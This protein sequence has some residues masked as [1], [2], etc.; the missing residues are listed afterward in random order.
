MV[1][2]QVRYSGM[3]LT[4]LLL[5]IAFTLSGC[6]TDPAPVR[7]PK[8]AEPAVYGPADWMG[9][10]GSDEG[11]YAALPGWDLAV[12]DPALGA[13]QLSCEAFVTRDPALPLSDAAPW[14]GTPRD[15]E[16]VCAALRAAADGPAGRAVLEALMTPLE[17]LDPSGESRFTGY[18]EPTYPARL[19][20]V[21]P[22][23][24]P[25]PALPSDHLVEGG[26]VLQRLPN[27]RTRP[28]PDR[29]TI[30][31]AGVRPLAYARPADVFFLQIQ[32]SGRLILPDGRTLRAAYAGHNGHAFQSTANWLIRRGWLPRSQASMTGIKTWMAR[33]SD[34]RMREA[35][36]ANPRFIFFRLEEEGDPALGPKGSMGVPLTPLG[37]VAVDLSYHA[38]G[39][40]LFVQTAAP[41]LGG[42]WS[43]LLVAQDTGNAIRGPVRGDIYFGTGPDAGS[44]ADTMNAPGRLWVLLPR[45]LARRLMLS[46]GLASAP[47]LGLPPLAP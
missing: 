17:I 41:G 47:A 1:A 37:S 21:P 2:N 24:E 32:G 35:M 9:E 11:A 26:R 39:V 15:W 18:F 5:L 28:Y 36:N 4:A 13:M 30:V 42:D 43:G 38:E 46:E 29:A 14:A 22:F 33:A 8:P 45:P 10:T 6:V 3:R 40:P 44:R 27:G 19:S 12:L 7:M 20:P 16:P 34:S 31:R 23:T 25:V